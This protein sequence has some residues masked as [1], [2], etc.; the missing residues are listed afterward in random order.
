MRCDNMRMSGQIDH[1]G[2]GPLGLNH[3][4]RAVTE[5]ATNKRKLSRIVLRRQ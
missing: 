5:A 4:K 2:I 3:Y 1:R